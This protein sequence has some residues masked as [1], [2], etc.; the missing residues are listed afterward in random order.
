MKILK[1]KFN[2]VKDKAISAG[3][4]SEIYSDNNVFFNSN[5][6][7]SSKDKSIVNA[8]NNSFNNSQ[9]YDLTAF[10]KKSFYQL[11]GKIKMIQKI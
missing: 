1:S 11:G 5:I 6:A 9:L 10:N 7:I 4:I 8:K 2:Y 3:E